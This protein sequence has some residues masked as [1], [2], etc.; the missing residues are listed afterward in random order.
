MLVWERGYRNLSISVCVQMYFAELSDACVCGFPDMFSIYC[1]FS[2]EQVDFIIFWV[3]IFWNQ[4]N[5]YEPGIYN[6]KSHKK[7]DWFLFST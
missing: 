1:I 6:T 3:V 2:E 4:M 5:S 7:K